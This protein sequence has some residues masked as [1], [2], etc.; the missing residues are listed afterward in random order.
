M[1]L[2]LTNF[3]KKENLWESGFDYLHEFD[4]GLLGEAS[5][6]VVDWKPQ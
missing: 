4:V 6:V 2:R 5:M 3:T 1:L